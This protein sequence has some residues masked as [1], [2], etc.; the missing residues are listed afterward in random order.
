MNEE[1]KSIWKRNFTGRTAVL[2]WALLAGLAIAL[3]VFIIALFNL[4]RP[5]GESLAASLLYGISGIVLVTLVVFVVWPLARLLFWKHWRRTLFG[6]ACFATLIALFYAEENWRGKR[7]WENYKH[8]WEAKG[9]KFDFKDFVPPPVPDEKNFAMTPIWVESMKATLGERNSRKWFGTNYAD[10]NGNTNFVGRLEFKIYYD[11]SRVMPA[12]EEPSV[13][14]WQKS[15]VT[16]LKK[17]QNYYREVGRTNRAEI[18][19]P[20]FYPAAIF[21]NSFSMAPQP[22]TPAQDV[23]LALG[24]FD[25]T[26]EELR[27]ASLLPECRFPLDYD[28]ECPAAILLPHLAVMERSSQLLQLRAIA[29]LQNGQSEKAAADVALTLRLIASLRSEPIMIS[30]L[31]R[32]AMTEIIVQPI[33]EGLAQHTWTESQLAALDAELAKLN[34]LE[35]N[36]FCLRS[37]RAYG[38]ALVDYVGRKKRFQRYQELFDARWDYDGNFIKENKSLK[39]AGVYLM[40]SGWFDQNKLQIAHWHKAWTLRVVEPEKQL[41]RPLAANETPLM[42]IATTPFNFFAM[43]MMPSLTNAFKKFA[44]GQLDTDLARTAI[45]LERYRLAHGEFPESLDALAPQFIAQVPH[46]VIGGAAL[47]YRREQDGTF[48]LYSIGWNEKDDGGVVVFSKG[49]TPSADFKQGDWV[50]RYPQK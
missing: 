19:Y 12:S 16:N 50:W 8:E 40:P 31:V 49:E 10:A 36:N 24:K 32:I 44:R 33:Y 20:P 3:T 29:E 22:Q 27:Q 18:T 34:F 17:W 30:H 45:A 42:G 41:V 26:V 38:V 39:A 13:A 35:D 25:S 28:N 1:P 2:V 23:L 6:L 47:K 21:T 11:E 37:E 7:A 46:D 5:L 14:N 15:E 43:E 48:K 4:D 9:E